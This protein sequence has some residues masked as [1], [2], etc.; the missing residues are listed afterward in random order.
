MTPLI[1]SLV[2]VSAFFASNTFANLLP[3]NNGPTAPP[4]S[5][6]FTPYLYAGCYTDSASPHALEFSPVG[7]EKQNMTVET[8]AAVCKGRL[9]YQH[10][11]D[12]SIT[13]DI[14]GTTIVTPD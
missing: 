11:T 7:L 12:V 6:P 1:K 10:L 3:R 5:V 4:C 2:T 9:L 8:C 14:Q 13:N